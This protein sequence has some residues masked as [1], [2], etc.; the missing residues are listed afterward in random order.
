MYLLSNSGGVH[1]TETSLHLQL[2][3]FWH[4]WA[5]GLRVQ[6]FQILSV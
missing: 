5:K 6:N 4:E 3:F 2:G 1:E